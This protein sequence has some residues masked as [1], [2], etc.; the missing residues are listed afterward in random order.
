MVSGRVEGSSG[1]GG[2]WIHGVSKREGIT[3]SNTLSNLSP[4]LTV[5]NESLF[6]EQ[7]R[8][9][10]VWE[11][12]STCVTG[13]FVREMPKEFMFSSQAIHVLKEHCQ[14]MLF[15]LQL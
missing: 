12:N 6:W 15:C 14:Y 11:I 3:A 13:L 1:V 2:T 4:F 10:T 8:D 9:S 5:S 7:K